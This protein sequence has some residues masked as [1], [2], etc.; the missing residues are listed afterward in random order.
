MPGKLGTRKTLQVQVCLPRLLGHSLRIC[1]PF[2]YL[3]PVSDFCCSLPG[4]SRWG[5]IW[6]RHPSESNV[7]LGLHRRRVP[8]RRFDA[9]LLGGLARGFRWVHALGFLLLLCSALHTDGSRSSLVCHQA[10]SRAWQRSGRLALEAS[11][12][13]LG[14]LGVPRNSCCLRTS[15]HRTLGRLVLL[16]CD[17]PSLVPLLL[18]RVS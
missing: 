2:S 7:G 14:M 11:G 8:A 16:S 9:N 5:R 15:L 4:S 3:F 17:D 1:A 10:Y 18:Y 13:I 12:T 6:L